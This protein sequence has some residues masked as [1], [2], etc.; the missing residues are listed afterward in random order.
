MN[1]MNEYINKLESPKIKKTTQFG[2]E[3][4]QQ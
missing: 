3:M 1:I 4:S 2:G